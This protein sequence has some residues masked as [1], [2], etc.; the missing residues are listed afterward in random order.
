MKFYGFN[1]IRQTTIHID[2]PPVL[3]PNPFDF[4]TRNLNLKHIDHQDPTKFHWKSFQ[5]KVEL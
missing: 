4:V 5:Q 2:E 1:N 3:E